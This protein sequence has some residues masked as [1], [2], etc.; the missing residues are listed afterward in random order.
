MASKKTVQRRASTV[1]NIRMTISGG[2]KNDVEIQ[3]MSELRRLGREERQS[4]IREAGLRLEIPPGEGLAMKSEL[5][6][7]WNKLRHIRR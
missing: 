5:G 2:E 3:R 7:P 6:I 1:E 4:I